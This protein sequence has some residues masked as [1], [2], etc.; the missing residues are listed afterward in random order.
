MIRHEA[1]AQHIAMWQYVF[2]YFGNEKQII[3]CRIIKIAWKIYAVLPPDKDNK[4]QAK[5][6]LA[7]TLKILLCGFWGWFLFSSLSNISVIFV[8]I[9]W[10]LKLPKPMQVPKPINKTKPALKK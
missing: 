4:V 7:L 1:I 2:T 6:I 10:I 9:Y 5:K 8:N 3:T